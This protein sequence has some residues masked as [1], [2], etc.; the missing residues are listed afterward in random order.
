MLIKLMIGE[1][2]HVQFSTTVRT[3]YNDT[4]GS[5][6]ICQHIEFYPTIRAALAV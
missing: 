2:K 5:K 1:N 3:Q 6:K 4:V